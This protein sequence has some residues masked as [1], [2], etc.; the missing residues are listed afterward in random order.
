MIGGILGYGM[1][2][3]SII[4]FTLKLLIRLCEEDFSDNHPEELF[5]WDESAFLQE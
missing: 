5:K 2:K 4:I 3:V 1:L